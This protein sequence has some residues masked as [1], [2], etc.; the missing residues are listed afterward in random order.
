MIKKVGVE[1][2]RLG[3]F[4]HDLNVGWMAHGFLRSRFLLK[5][6]ADLHRVQACGITALYIDTQ[7]GLDLAGAPTLAEAQTAA[8]ADMV[9]SVPAEPRLQPHV[10]YREELAAARNLHQETTRLLQRLFDAVRRGC[11]LRWEEALPAAEAIAE[12]VLRNGGALVSLCRRKERDTYTS[13]HSVSVAALL[14]LLG[15]RMGLPHRDLV[16]AALGGL[17]HDAGKATIPGEILA[18]PGKLT[19]EEFEVMK[20]HVWAGSD[21]LE[22]TPGPPL[23]VLRIAREHHERFAGTGYPDALPGPRISAPG[24][25]AA[26]ADVYDAMTSERVYHRALPPAQALARM[27]EWSR[28]HYDP[29]LMQAFIRA[30]GVYPSGS[31]VRLESDRLAIVLDQG[32]E[33][34]LTPTVRVFYD[35]HRLR[36][37]PPADLDLEAPES[38]GDAIRSW[39]DPEEWGVDAMGVVGG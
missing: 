6:E 26:L 12:S 16:E 10:S 14:V 1:D 34:L 24:R 32:G 3:M 33:G 8:F 7:K 17:L 18:K 11:P 2:L 36:S 21:L 37:I 13:Q 27:F 39:E 29:Q 28:Q 35:I 15:A 4:I 5:R 20:T 22:A 9:E 30:L 23:A 31:L 38:G 19:D 25:M